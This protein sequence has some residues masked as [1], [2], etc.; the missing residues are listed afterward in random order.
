MAFEGFQDI[1]CYGAFFLGYPG[2]VIGPHAVMMTDG[3]AVRDDCVGGG[4]LDGEPLF[5]FAVEGAGECECEVEAGAVAIAVAD[6]GHDDASCARRGHVAR[7]GVFDGLGYG[8]VKVD[9]V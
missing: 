1:H 3:S 7:E 5:D 8:R 2:E 4:F 6:V 9:D